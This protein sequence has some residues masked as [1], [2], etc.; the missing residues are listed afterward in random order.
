MNSGI[1]FTSEFTVECT[2]GGR[3]R[4][5]MTDFSAESYMYCEIYHIDEALRKL[6]IIF[7]RL[8]IILLTLTGRKLWN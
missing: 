1:G 8:N 5:G 2:R 6:Y 3:S 7:R 4:L